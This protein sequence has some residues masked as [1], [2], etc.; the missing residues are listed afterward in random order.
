M[1]KYQ[2]IKK[3]IGTVQLFIDERVFR[4]VYQMPNHQFKTK[5]GFII[6]CTNNIFSSELEPFALRL[7]KCGE[8]DGGRIYTFFKVNST[9]YKQLKQALTELYQ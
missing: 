9:N 2:E 8:D 5:N 1:I 3:I 4:Q 6:R 7:R